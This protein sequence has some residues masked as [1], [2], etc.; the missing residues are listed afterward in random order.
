V[1]GFNQLN[2]CAPLEAITAVLARRIEL[3]Q[4]GNRK[5]MKTWR[6]FEHPGV[7]IQSSGWPDGVG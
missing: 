2:D 1:R 3:D 5:A 6:R 4:R 7:Q